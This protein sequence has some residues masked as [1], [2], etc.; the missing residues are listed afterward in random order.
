[1]TTIQ[2][3]LCA[4]LRLLSDFIRLN[5]C[6]L[7]SASLDTGKAGVAVAL[8]EAS[9]T[10]QDEPM[11]NE[12]YDLLCETLLAQDSNQGMKDG[13]AGIGFALW[14][15]IH[16]RFV[17][18]DFNELFT[19]QLQAL[20]Q[21]DDQAS[22]RSIIRVDDTCLLWH[23]IGKEE[24]CR[25]AMNCTARL[26]TEELELMLA[27]K[28]GKMPKVMCSA[29]L[30]KYLRRCVL[31]TDYKPDDQVMQT[32]RAI[33][34]RGLLRSEESIG[35]YLAELADH[36]KE[37]WKVLSEQN[38]QFG[39]TPCVTQTQDI[40][41]QPIILYR[42]LQIPD[43][44]ARE[45][46]MHTMLTTY[47][48]SGQKQLEAT[49]YATCGNAENAATLKGGITRLLLLL[50]YAIDNERQEKELNRFHYWLI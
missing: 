31:I 41:E 13:W 18:A 39:C 35:F 49:L 8:F 42:R 17:E 27:G 15:L 5:I 10:L 46:A 40:S 6:S 26:L 36:H 11:E 30:A 32:Y 16:Y 47:V 21:A 1:M 22:E 48:E 20:R 34:A 23:A 25:R 24:R 44:H 37:S 29:L 50:C 14:Y 3:A 4:R 43:A 19:D 38:L 12:A 33:Y 45:Q 7:Q 28:R 2:T 9:R